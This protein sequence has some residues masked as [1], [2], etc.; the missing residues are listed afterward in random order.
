MTS[1]NAKAGTVCSPSMSR[2]FSTVRTGSYFAGISFT[3]NVSLLSLPAWVGMVILVT[4]GCV[5]S[6]H[7]DNAYNVN[8]P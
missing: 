2:A 3:N 1:P 5:N 6:V 8:V 4:A 7:L